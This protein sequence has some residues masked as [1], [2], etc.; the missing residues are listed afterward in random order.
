MGLPIIP[1]KTVRL[2]SFAIAESP[3]DSDVIA[4]PKRAETIDFRPASVVGMRNEDR[5]LGAIRNS[6]CE[7]SLKEKEEICRRTKVKRGVETGEK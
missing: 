3:L 1:K 7:A 4:R 2:K 5:S 6:V